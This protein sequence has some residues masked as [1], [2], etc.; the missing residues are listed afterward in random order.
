MYVCAFIHKSFQ[1]WATEHPAVAASD[2]RDLWE[3]VW[4]ARDQ[5]KAVTLLC[6]CSVP[7]LRVITRRR[8]RCRGPERRVTW[9][10]ALGGWTTGRTGLPLGRSVD[11]RWVPVWDA[12]HRYHVDP[13]H[14]SRKNR[15]FRTNKLVDELRE[16]KLCLFHVSNLSVPN[17]RFFPRVS[18]VVN[19]VG[20]FNW[21]RRRP[22]ELARI[23]MSGLIG[24]GFI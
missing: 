9:R 17:F 15:K 7:A 5:R 21:R 18:G 2:S 10:R 20:P 19:G 8:T 12:Q 22:V 23:D 16:S 11:G 24:M 4:H 3:A 14:M 6:T 1:F 13:G